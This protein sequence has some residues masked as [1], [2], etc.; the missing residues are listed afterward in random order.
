MGRTLDSQRIEALKELER[1]LGVAFPRYELLHQALI[2]KSFAN[3]QHLRGFDNE[4]L[5][6]LGDAVLELVISE[7]LYSRYTDAQEGELARLRSAVVSEH[8]LADKA[9]SLG[10]GKYLLLAH[11]EEHA[12]G[13]TLDSL[14]SDALEAVI[15]AMYL[16]VGYGTCRDFLLDLLGEEVQIL[17]DSKDFIDPKSALQEKVQQ[18]SHST[19]I[20]DV[21]LEQGPDHDKIFHVA[22]RW[23]GDILGKGRGKSKK[24]AEQAAARRALQ[25]LSRRQDW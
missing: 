12:G 18:Y 24:D 14:L 25:T 11:G 16:Q 3:E 4:R 19:P 21:F 8:A 13:R 23:Q 5:E 6:F 20:Y 1:R 15:G 17:W 9:R 7:Y 22:V 2:H 10:L